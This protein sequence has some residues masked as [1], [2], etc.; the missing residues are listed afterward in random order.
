MAR[1][2]ENQKKYKEA[3]LIYKKLYEKEKSQELKDALLRIKAAL[4]KK[5]EDPRVSKLNKILENIKDYKNHA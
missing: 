1:I 4:L 3:F 5:H 2:L